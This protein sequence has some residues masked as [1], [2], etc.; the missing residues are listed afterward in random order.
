[1]SSKSGETWVNLLCC[2]LHIAFQTILEQK[3]METDYIYLSGLNFDWVGQT[4]WLDKKIFFDRKLW[5]QFNFYRRKI[6]FRTTRGKRIH[7]FP[8]RAA[9]RKRCT[10]YI[11]TKRHGVDAKK[12]LWLSR[13]SEET[14]SLQHHSS[15]NWRSAPVVGSD[16]LG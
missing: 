10:I 16:I 4:E 12:P 1:M 2:I 15:E 9:R 5:K 14:V 6:Q 8:L 13:A 7:F 3:C 11:Q